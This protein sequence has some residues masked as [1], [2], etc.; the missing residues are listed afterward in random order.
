[1][2]DTDITHFFTG[3]G[4]LCGARV[5]CRWTLVESR[6]TCVAC[7]ELLEAR[8]QFDAEASARSVLVGRMRWS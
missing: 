8:E 6:T 3:E 2:A 1:M 7:R 4:A 5:A